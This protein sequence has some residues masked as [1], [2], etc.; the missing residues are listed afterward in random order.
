MSKQEARSRAGANLAFGLICAGWTFLD[1]AFFP[2]SPKADGFVCGLLAG[3]CFSGAWR[4]ARRR[5]AL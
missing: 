4:E 2:E 3:L 1:Y 5:T